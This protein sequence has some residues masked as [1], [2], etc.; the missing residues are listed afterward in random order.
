[1]QNI[2]GVVFVGDLVEQNGKTIRENNLARTH[3][4]PLGTIVEVEMELYSTSCEE[5]IEVDLRG[6]CR[7]YVVGHLRDCDG[8][9][10]YAV[11]DIP[12]KY[13]VDARTFSHERM[14]YDA[15]AKVIEYGYGEEVLRPIEG[16]KQRII[17]LCRRDV[18][19]G[20]EGLELFTAI[21]IMLIGV[22]G[23]KFLNFSFLRCSNKYGFY[24]TKTLPPILAQW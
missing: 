14:V 1:M 24:K 21:V 4:I 19:T 7:L 11:S 3:K 6:K 17:F 13:P 5:R 18:R 20:Y 16:A 12:V 9:P 15:I 2:P 10:L 22:G 8:T 23:K